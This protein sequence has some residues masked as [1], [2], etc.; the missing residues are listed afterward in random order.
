M[1]DTTVGSDSIPSVLVVDDE[2]ANLDTFKRVFRRDYKME[3]AE[4]PA[5]ALDTLKEKSFDVMLTDFSMPGMDGVDLI[6]QAKAMCPDL[7]CIIVTGFSDMEKVRESATKGWTAIVIA[8][9]WDRDAVKRWIDVVS[10]LARVHRSNRKLRDAIGSL[11][12]SKE[13]A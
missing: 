13:H 1:A 9:P 7:G 5:K 8:K 4:T 10:R 2:P 12:K 6:L 3:F 11:V